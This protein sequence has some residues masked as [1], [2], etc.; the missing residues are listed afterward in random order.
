MSSDIQSK[1]ASTS[2]GQA[3]ALLKANSWRVRCCKCSCHTMQPSLLVY[4]QFA[5]FEQQGGASKHTLTNRGQQRIAIKI[6]CSDNRLYK[7]NPVYSFLDPGA[8]EQLDVAR[9][10]GFKKKD[11][12]VLM[13]LLTKADETDAKCVFDSYV[14]KPNQL[15]LPLC[16]RE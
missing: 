4:P 8:S 2:E 6:K 16:V 14:D 5:V 11:K 10:G 7:V 3:A 12:L 1:R 15:I 9:G 13:F